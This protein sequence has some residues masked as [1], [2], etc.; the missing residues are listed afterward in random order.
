M[1][2]KVYCWTFLLTH[3]I[4]PLGSAS[5]LETLTVALPSKSFQFAIFSIAK[6][7]G[8]MKEEGIDLNIAFMRTA[9]GIQAL[10]AGGIQFSGSGSSALVAITKSG[11]PLKTVLAANKQVLQW[12]FVRPEINSLAELKDKKVAVAGVA[13][14]SEAMFKQISPKYGL[15]AA[16]DVVF[17]APGANNRVAA[18]VSGAVD[19]AILST[20]E[21]YAA[22]AHGMKEMMFLGKE[23]KNSWG[24]VATSDSFIREQPQLLTGVMK[25]LLKA[26][27][28]LRHDRTG[29]IA[30]VAKF[31]GLEEPLATRM[32]DDL[33]GT[34]T[35]NGTVDEETQENDLDVVRQVAK[36]T[37]PVPIG[38]A[39]DFSFAHKAGENLN[40][41]GRRP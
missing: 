17:L 6:D 31:S 37:K 35:A 41:N 9:S 34:F 22:R 5:S 18:L 30:A 33:I 11:A 16:K 10:L 4:L 23:V 7:R 8:Y 21:R 2:Y 1:R 32:Y 29:T 40:Q 24:T 38:Q 3:L 13:S 36:V 28:V 20:E 14:I 26:L 27:S 15:Q 25:A 19:G 12:V 39:Y